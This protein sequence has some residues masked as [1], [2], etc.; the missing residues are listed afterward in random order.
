MLKQ[1]HK[2]IDVIVLAKAGEVYGSAEIR[3]LSSWLVSIGSNVNNSTNY[4]ASKVT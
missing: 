3:D 4:W 1:I 2:Y